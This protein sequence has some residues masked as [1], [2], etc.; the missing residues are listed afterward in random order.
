MHLQVSKLVNTERTTS[1][2]ALRYIEEQGEG[3]CNRN[4][5]SL[6]ESE[7]K[8]WALPDHSALS[9]ATYGVCTIF[10]SEFIRKFHAGNAM[11]DLQ[12]KEK[13]WCHLNHNAVCLC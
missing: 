12:C 4:L 3:G 2:K 13:V 10:H 5:V 8:K 7:S 1:A 9:M 11:I 6:A